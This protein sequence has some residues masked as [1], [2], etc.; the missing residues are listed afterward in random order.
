MTATL[1]VCRH[2]PTVLYGRLMPRARR[3][4]L[5]D[6]PRPLPAVAYDAVRTLAVR[7]GS[8]W[9]RIADEVIVNTGSTHDRA[10]RVAG[11]A[12]TARCVW[13]GHLGSKP[14]REG[15]P[16]WPQGGNLMDSSMNGS[17]L[18]YSGESVLVTGGASFIGSHLV[19]LLVAQ[20]AR[21]RVADDFSSGSMPNLYGV[22]G[23]IEIFAGDLRDPGVAARAVDSVQT[24][25]HLAALHGGRGYIDTHPVECTSNM[26]LDHVVFSAAVAAGVTRLVHASS[27]C[28][29]PVDLQASDSERLLLRE[30]DANFHEP[31]KAFADGEYGW[32][33]L[34]G[35]LQL[36]A[37]HKQYGVDA[38]AARI[39]TAYGERE[40]ESHAVIALIAKAAAKLDPYPVWGDGKQT[41][42]FTYVRDT[43][44]GLALAGRLT[45]H[46][47]LNV[48][49]ARH[50]TVLEL[51]DVIFDH[52][53]WRPADFTFEL[54]KPVGVRSRA[55]DNTR[56]QALT[57]WE[58]E[59]SLSEGIARTIDW[60]VASTPPER[61]A[62]LEELL[63][64]R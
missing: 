10:K 36:H 57:S 1:L 54:D 32:A 58:P 43:V 22:S 44:Q 49:S 27:A 3:S 29:Y 11:L 21:V 20:G 7:G 6:S 53:Q 31:G 18:R 28:V 42:N 37:F 4:Q 47:V 26:Q 60:Y 46:Q 50:H 56:I 16:F 14:E 41:R 61:L 63:L 48:G 30:E 25:F 40:N 52:L 64:S 59:T 19:E 38:I 15:T 24:V 35:E 17:G 23:E 39:F 5:P 34:M 55:S 33:K 62:R 45:G 8:P 13:S 2:I 51:M 9:S 12:R